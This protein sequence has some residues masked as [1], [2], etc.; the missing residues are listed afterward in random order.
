MGSTF[1]TF[2]KV[3]QY[4]K[5][6]KEDWRLNGQYN[7]IEFANGSRIDFL[8]L[9][10]LP[11]D[12]MY[13]RFGSL[14]YTGGA[15]EEAGEVDFLS[16]D[17]LKSRI[18]RWKNDEYGVKGKILITCNPKKN[19]LY[20]MVYLPYKEKTLGKEYAFVQALYNDN[21]YSQKEYEENLQ[22]I[23]DVSNKKRLMMGDWEYDDDPSIL[24]KYDAIMDLFTNG[25]EPSITRYIT[26]DIARYGQDKTVIILWEG[27]WAQRIKVAEHKG[28]DEVAREIKDLALENQVP[29]SRI[30]V[31]EDG[32]GG[33]VV[34]ILRGI[35]GFQGGSRPLDNPKSF[36][37]EEFKNLRSQCYFRLADL[38][39]DRK[40]RLTC[41]DIKLRQIVIQELEQVKAKDLDADMKKHIIP[42]D[43]IKE[44]LGRSP[45]FADA[46]MMRIWFELN[47]YTQNAVAK[48]FHP[49]VFRYIKPIQ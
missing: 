7:Y 37:K 41:D 18:G 29:Y 49:Q 17:V 40:I 24:M 26:A 42:K 9:K 11:T 27:L 48:Q 19:W 23:T 13:E 31:D 15:I 38:V 8:D 45:D 34:D 3:C 25:A 28:M 35:K 46:L 12:P 21:P 10:Y 2:N 16:F 43:E 44:L 39:N 36:K 4:H 5:I 22:S 20:Q 33:G 30:I 14:E 1:I 6:P 32:V 47:P